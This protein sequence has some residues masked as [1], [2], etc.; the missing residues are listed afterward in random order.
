VKL[1]ISLGA[2][3]GLL[4]FCAA[5]LSAADKPNIL[6]ITSE[7]HGPHLGAYGDKNALTPNLDALAGRGMLFQRAWS[8]APVCAPARTTIVSGLF[9]TS[10]GGEHMRSMVPLPAGKK[11][12]PEFLREAGYYCTNNS[13]EDYNL[14]QPARVWDASSRQAHWKNRAAGQPFFA[15][16]NSNVT[17][18]GQIRKS[19]NPLKVDPAKVRVPAYHPDTPEVRR[20]WAQYHANVS[21]ADAVAGEHLAE[22]A[23]AALAGDTIVFYFADHGPG[24]PRS[25]RWPGNSG[26]HVPLIIYFPPKWRHLAPSDYTAGGKSDRLVSF[27]DFAPTVLSLAGIA[28][29]AWMQGRAFAGKFPANP[30]PYL[31]GFRGRMD[32]RTDLVRSVTDGRYVYLRNYLPHLSQGQHVNAQFN[33]A[34]T[35]QWRKLFD[36]GKLNEA[37]SLFWKTPKAP[38]ELYDLESDPDEVRNLAGSPAHREILAQ[39]RAAQQAQARAIRDVGFLPE[40]EMHARAAGTSPYDLARDDARFPFERVFAAAELASSLAPDAV[41]GLRDALLDTDG[42]VRYWS[43]LG[44]LMRGP[45][46]VENAA[47]DLRKTLGDPSPSVRIVAAWALAAH[48]NDD[49]ARRALAVLGEHAPWDRNNVFASLAALTAIDNLGA[50]AV[51]LREAVRTWPAEGPAPEPRYHPYVPQLLRSISGQLETTSTKTS[52]RRKKNE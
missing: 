20:D 45:A 39:L 9:A 27:V 6:W 25:K 49:D 23:A 42:A 40:G 14:T 21:A 34:T 13:K 28:P 17:H 8:N 50:K 11:M 41:P 44:F 15:V 31:H 3:G 51:G 10:S 12:Y 24:L 32:E 16:F 52:P 43:V 47:A 35:Q 18:E 5:P 37:Q 2:L 46:T 22:L 4:V 26:L 30:A 29:P 7:D 48:G 38:E 36:G 19:P 33:S 1:R